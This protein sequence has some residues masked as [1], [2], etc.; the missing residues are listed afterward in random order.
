[1]ILVKPPLDQDRVIAPIRIDPA[2]HLEPFLPYALQYKVRAREGLC[3]PCSLFHPSVHC[4]LVFLLPS[5]QHDSHFSRSCPTCSSRRDHPI[6]G[7]W[8]L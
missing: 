8:Q 4:S 6:R 3:L 2:G 1:M 7:R 5:F